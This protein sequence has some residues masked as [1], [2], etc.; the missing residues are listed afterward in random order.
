MSF[1]V[2]VRSPLCAAWTDEHIKCRL[3]AEIQTYGNY[4]HVQV[5]STLATP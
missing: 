1:K 3:A 5:W 4:G 2:E